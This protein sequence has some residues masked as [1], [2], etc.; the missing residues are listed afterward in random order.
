MT[1]I[2][3]KCSAEEVG[4]AKDAIISIMKVERTATDAKFLK[5]H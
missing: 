5:I 1:N 3:L 2:L 4:Y